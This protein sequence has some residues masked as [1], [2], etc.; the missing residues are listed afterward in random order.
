MRTLRNF[1]ELLGLEKPV[2]KPLRAKNFRGTCAISAVQHA[3]YHDLL[4]DRA[5]GL[6]ERVH[7]VQL[8]LER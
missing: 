5:A 4:R 2:D 6:S 1:M 8:R 3:P 7:S